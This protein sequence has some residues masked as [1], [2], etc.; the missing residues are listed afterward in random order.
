LLKGDHPWLI[1]PE[2]GMIKD[3]KVMENGK[4]RITGKDGKRRLPHTGAAALALRTEFFRQRL[5]YLHRQNP[6][7]AQQQLH[8]LQLVSLDEITDRQTFIV[9][10]NLSYYPFRSRENTLEKLATQFFGKIPDRMQ[11][12]LRTEGTMLF[13]G[14]RMDITIGEPVAVAPLLKEKGIQKDIRLT[15]NIQPDER[16]PSAARMRAA[17]KDLT[18]NIMQSVYRN[19]QVNY[20]HL[21]A[22]I[23]KCYPGRHLRVVDF[24]KRLCLAIERAS[25]FKFSPLIDNRHKAHCSQFCSYYQKKLHD[26]LQLAEQSGVAEIRQGIIYKK[27]QKKNKLIDFQT[28]RMDNPFQVIVNE[29]EVLRGLTAGLQRIAWYPHWLVNW[30]LNG[31]QNL[32][33]KQSSSSDANPLIIRYQTVKTRFLSYFGMSAASGRERP[34]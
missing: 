8:E 27:R 19:T 26:F 20:D 25:R 9:P 4:L 28:I 11:D 10:V 13:S 16:L 3:K 33:F 22:Y 15:H 6:S 5:R 23:L 17:A 7:M 1:F 12:E 24:A 14:V 34:V 32:F 31:K 21:A 29:A 18:V 30:Y 2:G